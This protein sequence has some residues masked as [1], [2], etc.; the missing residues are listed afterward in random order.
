MQLNILP[1]V[2]IGPTFESCFIKSNLF[3]IDQKMN[4]I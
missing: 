1:G 4:F 3:K 2:S